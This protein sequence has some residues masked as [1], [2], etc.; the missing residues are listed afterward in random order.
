MM[1]QK[2]HCPNHLDCIDVLLWQIT[3]LRCGRPLKLVIQRSEPSPSCVWFGLLLLEGT[4]TR[5]EYKVEDDES[6]I[7]EDNPAPR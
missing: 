5:N 7:P 1:R 3:L 2:Q 6:H 4:C